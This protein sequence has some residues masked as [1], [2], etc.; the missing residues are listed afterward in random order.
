M[1]P[2]TLTDE[3]STDVSAPPPPGEAYV[4]TTDPATSDGRNLPIPFR[5]YRYSPDEVAALSAACIMLMSRAEQIG[6]I[7]SVRG[8]H[9]R[10]GVLERL[11]QM[12]GETLRRLVFLTRRYCRNQQRLAEPLAALT[13]SRPR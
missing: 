5:T 12:D 11:P 4:D 7:N 3:L 9:L 2:P 6:V 1:F 8:G 10:P 13:A